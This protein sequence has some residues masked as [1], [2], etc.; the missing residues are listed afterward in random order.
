VQNP[1]GHCGSCRKWVPKKLK[2][3][4]FI[5]NQCYECH[6]HPEEKKMREEKKAARPKC[7]IDGCGVIEVRS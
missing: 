6:S 1:D 4:F 7:T 2:A 5:V 3:E